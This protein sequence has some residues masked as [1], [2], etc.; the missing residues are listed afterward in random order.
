MFSWC[1]GDGTIPWSAE[2]SSSRNRHCRWSKPSPRFSRSS[3][4]AIYQWKE[5]SHWNLI[6]PLLLSSSMLPSWRVLKVFPT[7]LLTTMNIMVSIFL[8]GQLWSVMHGWYYDHLMLMLS[9]SVLNSLLFRS[10]LHDHKIFNNPQEFQ[11]E[12]YLKD[13]KLNPDVRDQDCA[14]FG[15]GR[16]SVNILFSRILVDTH[17]IFLSICPGRHLA[18]NSLYSI[19]SCVL[20]VYDIEQP[21]DNQENI[22]NLKPEFTS[23]FIT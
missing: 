6:S 1:P 23:G 17:Q 7:C 15:F 18:D 2:E 20:A 13:G 12:R 16:P 9:F 8:K 14:V 3:F 19:I 10:I 5:S 21:V 11:P 4:P 22:L